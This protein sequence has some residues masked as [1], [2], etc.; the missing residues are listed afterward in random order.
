MI[1]QLK[2][3]ISLL[4]KKETYSGLNYKILIATL[5]LIIFGIIIVFSA[6]SYIADINYGDKFY[7]L[8]K[9][10]FGAI[11][12][13]GVLV[14]TYLTDY[15]IYQKYKN[16]FLIISI[17]LLLLVFI[18]GLGMSNN[19]ASRWIALPGFT[20]QPSEIAK[21]GFVIFASS[22]LAKNYDII[23]T[24]KGMLPVLATGGVICILILLEPNFSIT[25][26]VGLVTLIMLFVGGSSI[27][28]FALLGAGIA[29]IVPL[30]IIMEPYRIKRLVAFLDPWATPQAEGYQ[31]IQSF[32]SLGG[33]GLFGV[34]LFN[35]RQKYLFLP[36]AESDFIFSI[37]G[38][39]LGFI[40][41]FL[42]L[43]VFAVLIING[44]KV[45][46]NSL[47]RF[48]CYLATGIIAIIATQVLINVAVV[49][50]S[51]PPT[52]VPLPFI[53]S[54]S[55]ALV[56]FMASIGVLLNIHKQSYQASI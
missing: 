28:N 3:K 26:C 11:L 30:L 37:I 8:K 48:G 29:P 15:H 35:S 22:Y 7:F 10:I 31:L 27:K 16:Y 53:S 42:L 36:F 33:G 52:G 40:G 9:Q 46:Y 51:I 56:V 1:K 17:V 39:E 47:D 25:L 55:T 54:G 32:F 43:M 12:G 4:K 18:P 20:I 24:L 23:R 13:A 14:F 5:I 6:S 41:A 49:T 19:G 34:G 44:I 45:A 2:A 38:E 21:F 50:G